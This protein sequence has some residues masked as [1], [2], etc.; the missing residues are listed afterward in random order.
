MICIIL[1]N[2]HYDN[3]LVSWSVLSDERSFSVIIIFPSAFV[4]ADNLNVNIFIIFIFVIVIKEWIEL[5]S[6]AFWGLQQILFTGGWSNKYK[7]GKV[8]GWFL[9]VIL[10][11]VKSAFHMAFHVVSWHQSAG[12][13]KVRWKGD[14][15][16]KS[17]KLSKYQ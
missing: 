1:L 6:I 8:L 4:S 7:H 14:C 12:M 11:L 5:Y 2:R 3:H 9:Y 15:S 17:T 13:M 16:I 10:G